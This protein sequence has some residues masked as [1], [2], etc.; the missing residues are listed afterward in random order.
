MGSL[1]NHITTGHIATEAGDAGGARSFQPMNANFGLFPPL[2]EV[3]LSLG[4][5]SRG[6]EAGTL[7]KRALAARAL[8]DIDRWLDRATPDPDPPPSL[9]PEPPAP[10][11]RPAT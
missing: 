4:G 3:E 1:L 8:A 11:L 9:S 7:R 2:S 5:K 6:K 10:A